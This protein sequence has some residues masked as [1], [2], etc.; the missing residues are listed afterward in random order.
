MPELTI[1]GDLGNATFINCTSLESIVLNN[2]SGGY[3]VFE[4]C[5][6]LINA[7]V[8]VLGE[9]M[10]QGCSSLTNVTLSA[11]I[12]NIPNHCFYDCSLL[13]SV[14]IIGEI[15][16]VEEYAFYNCG[17]L[18]GFDLTTVKGIINIYAFANSGLKE[19]SFA[20]GVTIYSYAF[21][22]LDNK[23]TANILNDF[24]PE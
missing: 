8:S 22:D 11:E 6:S 24:N 3:C 23:V 9:R 4:G 5:T 17:E 7:T 18:E 20:E 10:F 21:K 2:T 1:I 13:N 15:N 12:D 16:N 14:N 19:I